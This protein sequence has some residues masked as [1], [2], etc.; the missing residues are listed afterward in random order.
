LFNPVYTQEFDADGGGALT[1]EAKVLSAYQGEGLAAWVPAQDDDQ[2]PETFAHV[3][4][5]VDDC[6]DIVGCYRYV[7]DGRIYGTP[8]T[9]PGGPYGR[10]FHW[11]MLR[12]EPCSKYVGGGYLEQD[13]Y[14]RLCNREYPWCEG[15]CTAV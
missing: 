6:P 14:D 4:L 10:C 13:K 8:N 1:Y 12:C 2:L 15:N 9:V 3:S 11:G 7:A 5:F